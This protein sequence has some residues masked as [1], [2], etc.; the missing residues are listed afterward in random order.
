[1]LYLAALGVLFVDF[2]VSFSAGAVALAC[3]AD[4]LSLPVVLVLLLMSCHHI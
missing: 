2:L 3:A 1:M 4:A